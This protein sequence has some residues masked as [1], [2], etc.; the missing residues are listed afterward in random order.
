MPQKQHLKA[1]IL[2][3]H[4]KLLCLL[5]SEQLPTLQW[6]VEQADAD[7]FMQFRSRYAT[8]FSFEYVLKLVW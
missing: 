7:T 6:S 3:G 2:L 4:C 8:T 5:Q 1:A